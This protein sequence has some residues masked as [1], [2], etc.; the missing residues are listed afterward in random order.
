MRKKSLIELRADVQKARLHAE[1][2]P[3]PDRMVAYMKF[4]DVKR[5]YQ[6]ALRQAENK[7]AGG[8]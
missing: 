8:K 7:A 5:T 4:N 2:Q 6:I 1:A 3:V